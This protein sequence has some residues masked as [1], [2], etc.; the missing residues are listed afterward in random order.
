MTVSATT[1]RRLVRAARDDMLRL[2]I[3][4]KVARFDTLK[5]LNALIVM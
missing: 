2:K 3:S 1:S 4:E 5:K